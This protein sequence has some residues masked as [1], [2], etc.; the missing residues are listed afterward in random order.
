M[1][2]G[3][4]SRIPLLIRRRS[5]RVAT[6]ARRIAYALRH[7]AGLAAG[8]TVLL[9]A[10]NSLHYPVLVLGIIAAGLICSPANVLLK[11][12]EL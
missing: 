4:S 10:S 5:T 6:L 1:S 8:D 11:P 2:A 12:H 7:R 9:F 3:I